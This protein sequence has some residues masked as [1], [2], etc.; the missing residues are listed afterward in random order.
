MSEL[1]TDWLVE[2]RLGYYPPTRTGITHSLTPG[3]LLLLLWDSERTN[4]FIG[5]ETQQPRSCLL[6]LQSDL[7][8]PP[9][10]M[11]SRFRV[12]VGA[13]FFL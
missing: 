10:T 4:A 1:M 13:L 11:W 6:V 5:R 12:V 2:D 8:H 9:V 3:V 7:T